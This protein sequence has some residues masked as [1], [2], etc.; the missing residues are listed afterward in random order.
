MFED[1]DPSI[2]TSERLLQF[3][4]VLL[5]ASWGNW[6]CRE[7]VVVRLRS[8]N[9]GPWR[10][11]PNTRW[12]FLASMLTLGLYITLIFRLRLTTNEKDQLL[13]CMGAHLPTKPW[14]TR[15]QH[16]RL[17]CPVSYTVRPYLLR[18]SSEE[19]HFTNLG[20]FNSHHKSSLIQKP[21][22]ISIGAGPAVGDQCYLLLCPLSSYSTSVTGSHLELDLRNT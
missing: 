3:F 7:R 17:P 16:S 18:T 12:A 11:A 4:Y 8:P 6:R 2:C 21:K 13:G 15:L 10:V 22:W 5:R 9:K 1:T 20:C 19:K 14:R